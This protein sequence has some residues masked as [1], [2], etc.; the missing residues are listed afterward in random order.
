V[1]DAATQWPLDRLEPLLERTLAVW[2]AARE[3][4]GV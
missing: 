3:H 1:S 2:H 4:A